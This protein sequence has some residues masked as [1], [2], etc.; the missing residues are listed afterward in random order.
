MKYDPLKHHRRSVRLKGYDYCYPGAYFITLVTRRR[1]C[2]LGE[3]QEG[4]VHLSQIGRIVEQEWCKLGKRFAALVVDEFIVMPNH[5]HGILLIMKE[6][7]VDRNLAIETSSINLVHGVKSGTLGAMIGAYK[8]TT[9]RLINRLRRTP[10]AQ[11]WQRNYYEHIIRNEREWK[12]TRAY[13]YNNP[14]KWEQDEENQWGTG[15]CFES[16]H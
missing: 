1:E 10:G 7:L 14:L 2:L 6:R 11:V 15:F 13:I 5:V 3:I 12:E 9:S 16:R 4:V 8:S